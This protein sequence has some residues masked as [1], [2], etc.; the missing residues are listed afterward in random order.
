MKEPD[1]KTM[2]ELLSQ[3]LDRE[4]PAATCDEL[5]RHIQNCAPCVEFVN[6]LRQSIR[7]C[8]QFETAE[9]PPEIPDSVKKSLS[10]AYRQML[11]SRNRP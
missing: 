6:S 9:Q 3:Y 2:F 4:L 1:C 8:R 7:L 10:A 5:E 11:D